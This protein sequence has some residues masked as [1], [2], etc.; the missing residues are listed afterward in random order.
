MYSRH[1]ANCSTMI[2]DSSLVTCPRCGEFL[3]EIKSSR[4]V[5]FVL[6]GL[7]FL[8]YFLSPP[9]PSEMIALQSRIFVL[10]RMICLYLIYRKFRPY[11]H[12]QLLGENRKQFSE[13]PSY[14]LYSPG[15]IAWASFWGTPLG[16]FILLAINYSRLGMVAHRNR[17]ILTGWC[18]FIALILTVLSLPGVAPDSSVAFAYVLLMWLYAKSHFGLRY[19]QHVVD[20]GQRASSWAAFGV[21]IASLIIG[22]VSLIGFILG[23]DY[24]LKQ[25]QW[26]GTL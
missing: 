8:S 9:N 10:F 7:C 20:E 12:Q 5:V 14:R 17:L 23:L 4:I 6:A 1:C 16:G 15:Q 3:P 22:S 19:E 26:S 13:K 11:L 24:V 21:G 18:A 2:Q 25:I